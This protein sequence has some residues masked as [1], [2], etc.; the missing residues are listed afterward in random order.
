MTGLPAVRLF[1]YHAFRFIYHQ[2]RAPSIHQPALRKRS[3]LLPKQIG[4]TVS[5][6]ESFRIHNLI[7]HKN[8][9]EAMDKL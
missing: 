2:G 3:R 4:E 9:V 5:L 6:T 8:T 1:C 7:Y